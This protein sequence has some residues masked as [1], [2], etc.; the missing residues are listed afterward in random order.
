LGLGLVVESAGYQ[1]DLPPRAPV[2]PWEK[3]NFLTGL[4]TPVP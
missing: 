1:V 2:L 3:D 4:A